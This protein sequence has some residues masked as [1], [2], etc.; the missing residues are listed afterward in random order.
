MADQKPK[1]ENE[2]L[3]IAKGIF[4]TVKMVTNWQDSKALKTERKEKKRK[5]REAKKA[6]RNSYRTNLK[7]REQYLKDDG[8]LDPAELADLE[9][10]ERATAKAMANLLK[11]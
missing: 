6:I 3:T 4:N 8:I 2:A 9:M 11:F 10:L 1:K 5:R 7:L